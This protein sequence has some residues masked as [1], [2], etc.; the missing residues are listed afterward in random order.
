MKETYVDY[1]PVNARIVVDY[2]KPPKEMV[3]FGYPENMTYKQALDKFGRSAFKQVGFAFLVVE[4]LAIGL[5]YL[6][7][8]AVSNFQNGILAQAFLPTR[9][10]TS[11][12]INVSQQA[13]W[14]ALTHPHYYTYTTIVAYHPVPLFLAIIFALS[15]Y[16]LVL[17]LPLMLVHY[18]KNRQEKLSHI[19]PKLNYDLERF[20][21]F[22]KVKHLK[23]EPKDLKTNGYIIPHFK[24]VYLDY[25]AEGDMAEQLEKIEVLEHPYNYQWKT[26]KGRLMGKPIINHYDWFALFKFKDVCKDG[27]IEIDYI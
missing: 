5:F 6:S 4:G 17:F 3:K 11:N 22:G 8:L 1:L 19:I 27:F 16:V 12:A 10:T 21:H 18:Y 23:I 15:Y 25:N 20:W 13:Y 24:N 14:F 26:K 7:L 9:T 2:T